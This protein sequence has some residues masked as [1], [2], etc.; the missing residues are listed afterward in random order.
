VRELTA[1]GAE[2]NPNTVMKFFNTTFTRSFGLAAVAA[3]LLAFQPGADAATRHGGGR[4]GSHHGSVH[5]SGG[6]HRGGV[7]HH[8]GARGGGYAYH[9]AHSRAWANGWR[10][11]PGYALA[12]GNGWRGPGYYYGA[13]GLAYYSYGPG[14]AFYSSIDAAP[15]EIRVGL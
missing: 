2:T 8:G 11:H 9:G 14:V 15:M 6:G 3:A 5:H 7:A 13:P 1:V 10:P 4:S 12:W